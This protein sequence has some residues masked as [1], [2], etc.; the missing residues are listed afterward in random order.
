[1]NDARIERARGGDREAFDVLFAEHATSLQLF[2]RY[3]MGRVRDRLESIDLVQEVYLQAFDRFEQFRGESARD[4][5]G[6]LFG[7]ARHRLT[8][9]ARRGRAQRRGA[10]RRAADGTLTRLAHPGPG[11]RTMA[12]LRDETRRVE[13]AFS[14]LSERDQ[15]VIALRHFEA[16]SAKEAA[17][18]MAM[19]ENA[20]NVLFFRAM[21]RWRGLLDE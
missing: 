17:A 7:I 3:R 20:L 18:R 9:Q 10:E 4:L 19:T 15:E 2:L 1:M 21:Q 12:V 13:E 14:Q 8:D 6:W 11:P 16:V 5:L